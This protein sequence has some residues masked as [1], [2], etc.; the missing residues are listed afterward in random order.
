VL[1]ARGP[2]AALLKLRVAG[3]DQYGH[4]SNARVPCANACKRT[5]NARGTP[6]P[7]S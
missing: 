6:A 3:G 1:G 2:P 4:G 7:S 5:L